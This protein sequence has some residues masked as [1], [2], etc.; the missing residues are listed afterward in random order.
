MDCDAA[1]LGGG[2]AGLAAAI[3]LRQAGLR[4]LCVEPE[5]FPHLYVGESLDWSS[6]SLLAELGLSREALVAERVATFKRNIKVVAP[7]AAVALGKPPEWWARPPLRFEFVTLHVDRQEMDDRLYARAREAGVEFLWDQVADVR[8]QGERVLAVTTGSGRRLEAPWFV[9]ASGRRGRLFAKAFG[10][11][12][13]DYGREKVSLWSYLATPCENEGTTF[14]IEAPRADYLSW[15][16][17]IPI[18]PGVASVGLVTEAAAVAAERRRGRT[19]DDIL[20]DRLAPFPRFAPLLADQPRLEVRSTAYRCFVLER[21]CGPNWLI[22]GEAASLPDALT[23]NG[24]TAA[25]RHAAEG[26]G[27]IRQAE[28]QGNLSRRQRR[29]YTANVTRMG[30]MFNHSMETAV[31]R[32]AI[33]RGLGLTASQFIYVTCAF[34]LNA[35]YTRFRPGPWRSRLAFGFLM[36]AAWLWIEG[37]TLVGRIAAALRRRRRAPAATGAGLPSAG[38]P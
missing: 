10:I 2:V 26:A 27:L 19:L 23:G 11:R 6:P 7:G 20:R 28:G 8:T 15:I 1:I 38:V 34:T 4:V 37:W 9:D 24:V 32:P 33:R 16:W 22:A 13:H 29:V 14:Y 3:H 17:E 31:Y 18:N 36:R 12:R 25:F 35:L 21:V 5:P 30:H